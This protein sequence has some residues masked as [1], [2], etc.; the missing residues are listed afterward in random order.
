MALLFKHKF[1]ELDRHDLAGLKDLGVKR[2]DP[3]TRFNKCA[4]LSH[5][6]VFP[7]RHLVH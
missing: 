4:E 2:D 7:R 1:Q 3:P 6:L 5:L